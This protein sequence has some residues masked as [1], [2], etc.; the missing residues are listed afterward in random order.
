MAVQGTRVYV[1][2]DAEL[3]EQVD[4]LAQATGVSTAAFIRMLCMSAVTSVGS[5]FAALGTSLAESQRKGSDD[6][7]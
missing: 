4:A 2:M 5:A 3:K 6:E 7:S 1:S